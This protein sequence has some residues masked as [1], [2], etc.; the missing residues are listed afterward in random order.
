MAYI[1]KST[2]LPVSIGELLREYQTTAATSYSLAARYGM[3]QRH[4]SRI[5]HDNLNPN[6]RKELEG[7][8]KSMAA[9]RKWAERKKV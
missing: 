1:P 7:E 8:K 2:R 4:I 3:G 6:T 9:K 5:L